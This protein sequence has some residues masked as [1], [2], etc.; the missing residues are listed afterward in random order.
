LEHGIFWMS[1]S[2]E[3]LCAKCHVEVEVIP[4][5]DG[6]PASS[7]ALKEQRRASA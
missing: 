5:A 7:D 3:M 1:E 2:R 6:K 4:D